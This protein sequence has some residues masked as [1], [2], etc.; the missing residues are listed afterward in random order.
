M[1][2]MIFQ[3]SGNAILFLLLGLAFLFPFSE[4]VQFEGGFGA[5][6][7]IFPCLLLIYLVA[8]PVLYYVLAK[9]NRWKDKKGS[10]LA[11]SDEREKAIVAEATRAAY[12]VLVGGLIMSIA[13]IGGVR[14]LSLATGVGISI[15]AVSVALLMALLVVATVTYCIKWCLEYRK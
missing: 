4:I 5:S 10:E 13:A 9:K 2:K 8:F 3:C 15:Y 11:Y 6:V 1:N 7:S 14:L 12:L